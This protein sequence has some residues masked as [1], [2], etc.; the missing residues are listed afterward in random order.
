MTASAPAFFFAYRFCA[1][2]CFLGYGFGHLGLSLS[3]FG[4]FFSF[5]RNLPPQGIHS[6][7]LLSYFRQALFII[8]FIFFYASAA[9]AILQAFLP[10]PAFPGG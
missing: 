3:P 8:S 10:L 4:G 6:V 7:T 5:R 9:I 2:S 1:P